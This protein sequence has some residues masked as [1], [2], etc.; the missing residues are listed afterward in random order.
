M[1]LFTIINVLY[2][3]EARVVMPS[4]PLN[5]NVLHDDS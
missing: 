2:I 3:G 4:I 1:S 5:H